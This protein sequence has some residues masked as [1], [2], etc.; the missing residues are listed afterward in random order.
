MQMILQQII[1]YLKSIL[2]KDPKN[3]HKQKKQTQLTITNAK[4]KKKKK[5]K[6]KNRQLL[7]ENT[8]EII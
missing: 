2:S 4:K 1:K 3:T 8:L 7:K 5:K 6:K